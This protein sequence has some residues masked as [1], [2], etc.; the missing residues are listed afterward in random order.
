VFPAGDEVASSGGGFAFRRGSR[1]RKGSRLSRYLSGE[2]T[3]VEGRG[4][5]MG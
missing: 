2:G 5:S 1:E 3:E 4:K